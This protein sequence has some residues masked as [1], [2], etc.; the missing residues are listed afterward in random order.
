[1]DIFKQEIN[2]NNDDD[3]FIMHISQTI[4]KIPDSFE[5]EFESFVKCLPSLHNHYKNLIEYIERIVN[6]VDGIL[7]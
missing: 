1:M 6:K 5:E 7:I 3:E 4:P 2:I